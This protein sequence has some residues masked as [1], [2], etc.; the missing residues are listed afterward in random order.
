MY[1]PQETFPKKIKVPLHAPLQLC[2]NMNCLGVEFLLP[3]ESQATAESANNA[4]SVLMT[5]SAEICVPEIITDPKNAKDILR[6]DIIDLLKQH[7]LAQKKT[8][9]D[10][11]GKN[12]V[13]LMYC[14][15]LLRILSILKI[16]K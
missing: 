14:G 4:F 16:N 1:N 6:N 11:I 12:F 10:S 3:C 9:A 7:N 8:V 2:I 13:R 5:S 15:M